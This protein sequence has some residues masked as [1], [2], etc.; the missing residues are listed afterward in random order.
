MKTP[1]QESFCESICPC[2]DPASG[3]FV[4]RRNDT[5]P[6]LE[7]DIKGDKNRPVDL[8]EWTPKVI[9]FYYSRAYQYHD[10]ET[11]EIILNNTNEIREGD[12]LRIDTGLE[13]MELVLVTEVDNTSS[14][15][16]VERGH[17]S[18]IPAPIPEGAPF[19]CIIAEDIPAEIHVRFGEVEDPRF[20]TVGASESEDDPPILST[21]VLVKWRASDTSRIGNFYIQ[22]ELTSDDTDQKLTIPRKSIGYP[23]YITRDANNS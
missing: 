17:D 18:T 7:I 20:H 6:I 2:E 3:K 19:F 15:I 14:T 8:S 5:C 16:I 22:V 12:V 4:I 9:L 23:I 13:N 1:S 21:K 10:D 11:F